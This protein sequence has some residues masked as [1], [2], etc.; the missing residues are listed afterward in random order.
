MIRLGGRD[1]RIK[2]LC[3]IIIEFC[4]ACDRVKNN[5]IAIAQLQTA[6]GVPLHIDNTMI[7]HIT[8]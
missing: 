3:L 4:P 2:I 5:N 8:P 7:I 6:G 1:V